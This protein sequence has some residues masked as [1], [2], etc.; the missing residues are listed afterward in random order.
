M[1]PTIF[2]TAPILLLAARADQHNPTASRLRARRKTNPKQEA[3]QTKRPLRRSWPP[4]RPVHGTRLF[5][6]CTNFRAAPIF[7]LGVVGETAEPLDRQ[8]G[9]PLQC[10]AVRMTLS[11][12][13]SATARRGTEPALFPD[14]SGRRHATLAAPS[15]L[16]APRSCDGSRPERTFRV[17]PQ[18][19]ES[20]YV[21]VWA[22]SL[23]G[24]AG[25]RRK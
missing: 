9:T 17:V 18:A 8:D 19:P 20:A 1:W 24:C 13:P 16:A 3:V 21:M 4:S 23:A 25:R 10:V 6:R 22:A 12:A 11:V 15:Y 2:A 7:R 14:A 5:A